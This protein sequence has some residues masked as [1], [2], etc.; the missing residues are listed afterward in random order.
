MRDSEQPVRRAGHLRLRSGQAAR[1][2][3]RG[4]ALQ[5]GAAARL[6]ASKGLDV[7]IRAFASVDLPDAR[8]RIAGD[9]PEEGALRRLCREL[10]VA[11]RVE[12]L[13]RL[14]Q[15]LELFQ[16]ADVV[17]VPSRD[18]AFP[19]VVLEAFACGRCVIASA[20]GGI[21]EAVR[22]GET[23]LLVRPGDP[24]DLAGALSEAYQSPEL[25]ARL[26]AAARAAYEAE[27]T[28]DRMG[29]RTCEVYQEVLDEPAR[30]AHG[31]DPVGTGAAG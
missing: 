8:L 11:D 15:A 9:G 28:A 18:D 24:Q 31:T 1:L 3:G 29:E 12:F 2:T 27:F 23:G 26:G 4:R 5:I 14:P 22:D 30:M 6:V 10:G 21:P 25:R 19:L 13:G 7:L 17:V 20:V 16:Q